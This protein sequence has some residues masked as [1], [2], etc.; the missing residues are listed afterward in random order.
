MAA[1]VQLAGVNRKNLDSTLHVTMA[2]AIQQGSFSASRGV[3][4]G[5]GGSGSHAK[6]QARPGAARFDGSTGVLA[7]K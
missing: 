4:G 6:R 5:R 3:T 7:S 2:R 1:P